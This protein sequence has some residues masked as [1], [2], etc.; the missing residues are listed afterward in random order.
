[1]G[2]NASTLV[3]STSELEE[4]LRV[5][6]RI[7]SL[8]WACVTA[9]LGATA[10]F[11][12]WDQIRDRPTLILIQPPL[13]GL[14]LLITL[15]T[16]WLTV[17]LAPGRLIGLRR[18]RVVEWVFV[19]MSAGFFVVNQS[20]SLYEGTAY[21]IRDN[22]MDLGAGLGAPWGAFIIYVTG[23]VRRRC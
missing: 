18:L 3:Q 10:I 14:L 12:H 5:R 22:S 2:S 23:T 4:Q 16:A 6:L 17:V 15:G 13:P 20:L 8:I 7:L 19:A 21:D 11:T 9:T 1:M